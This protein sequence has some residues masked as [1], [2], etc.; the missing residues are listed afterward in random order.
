MVLDFEPVRRRNTSSGPSG[1]NNLDGL[2]SV[3][4]A[5]HVWHWLS[6]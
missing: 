3:I 1:L 2:K 6:R 5:M 4:L